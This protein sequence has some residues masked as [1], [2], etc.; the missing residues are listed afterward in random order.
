MT[1]IALTVN[2][3][4]HEADV[5]P[6][7]LLVYFLREELG[8]KGTNVGCD[9]SSCGACT[10][11]VDGESVKSCNELA[12]QA[13]GTEVTTIEG[14]ASGDELHP[15]QQAFH[16]KHGLQCGYCTPGFVMASVSLLAGEPGS[17]RGG[18]PPGARG[19]PLPLHRVPQHRRGGTGRRAGGRMIPA[20]FEY[21]RAGSVDHAI[22]L[23]AGE[24]AKLL[25]GGQSLIPVL[26]LRFARP[27]LLVDVGRLDDLRYVRED[28]D[29]IAIGALTRHAELVRDPLLARALRGDPAGRRAHRRPAG[30]PSRHDRRLGRARD[31]ASDLGTILL[32]LDAEL[33]ARGPDGERTIPATE[34][35]TGPFETALEPPRD[36][37]RDPG[38]GGRGGR[39]P[40]AALAAR[41]DW[42]TVGVAAARVDG[43]VQVG[44]TSMGPTPLRRERCEEAL[45]SGASAGRRRRACGRGHRPAERHE[46]E[47]RVP[48]AP[49]A[50]ARPSA[51]EQL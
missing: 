23:L 48:R 5:E 14:L 36:A 7:E 37:D 43:R 3:T 40:Q 26:R 19:Q 31:P 8:L 49:R 35:F 41:Q 17:L 34:F 33:V 46:R 6:R 20:A 29:R 32:T 21:E 38:A 12:V 47:H 39:L 4:R 24:D 25:A 11:L 44:L 27:S 18:D 30:T 10:V 45:A 9:T 1:R 22:E 16:E 28:G 2:G 15:V 51:L 42:A 50:G 13:D